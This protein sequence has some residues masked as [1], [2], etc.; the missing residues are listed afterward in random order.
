MCQFMDNGFAFHVPD[1]NAQDDARAAH[2][3]TLQLMD[4]G[5]QQNNTLCAI[6]YGGENH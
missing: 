6:E 3:E 1:R 4:L 5:L 2:D